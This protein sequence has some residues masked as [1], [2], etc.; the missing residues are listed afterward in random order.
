MNLRYAIL[1]RVSDKG[2]TGEKKTSIDQ[3][4]RELE[5]T[6]KALKG[7]IT[8]RYIGQEH[9]MPGYERRLLDELLDDSG[10]DLFDCVAVTEPSRWSR[11]NSRSKQDLETLKANGIKF[12]ARGR[13]YN[14]HNPQDRYELGM[15]T[16]S[17]QFFAEMQAYKCLMGKVEGAKKG[18]LTTGKRPPGRT[19]D[20]KRGWGLDELKQRKIAK[21]VETYLAGRDSFESIA[22]MVGISNISLWYCFTHCLGDKWTIHFKS[23]RFD[24]FEDVTIDIP[25]LVPP[26]TEQAVKARLQSNKT[27]THGQYKHFYLLSRMIFCSHC[28]HVLGVITVNGSTYYRH[29]AGLKCEFNSIKTGLIDDVVMKEVFTLFGDVKARE[30]AMRNAAA[31]FRESDRL[32]ADIEHYEQE[33][34][35][36]AQGR[37]RVVGAVERGLLQDSE[38][39]RKMNEIR[40]RE[41]LVRAKAETARKEHDGM[42]T[43]EYIEQAAR[44]FKIE[45]LAAGL[46]HS[47]LGSESHLNELTDKEKRGILLSILNGK[48][49]ENGREYRYGVYI[50]RGQKGW[51]YTIRGAFPQV[52]GM[53]RDDLKVDSDGLSYIR[54]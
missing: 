7:T 10:K 3:Q 52:R 42:V 30:R 15:T 35:R 20:K 32:K 1:V 16:E 13:R 26:E 36:I 34:A 50:E 5:S 44:N 22:K 24:I 33:L 23:K 37:D 48:S 54:A 51:L 18:F 2:Q 21:A 46:E 11:D 14:L 25:R 19:Y 43:E 40:D 31:G 28:N 27:C 53:I 39:E 41:C 12:F 47:H 38:V 4:T 17:N 6:V 29:R 45:E 49:I 8:R 9:G